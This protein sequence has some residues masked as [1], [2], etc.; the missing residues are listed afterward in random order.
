[1][2]PIFIIL[3][4]LTILL[5]SAPAVYADI[6]GS[7]LLDTILNRY[8]SSAKT[9]ASTILNAAEWLFWVLV[10]ISLVWTGINLAFKQGS[11]AEFFGEFIRFI[12]VVGL[13]YWLLSNSEA[14]AGAILASL[15]QLG[16]TAGNV[17]GT[18]RRRTAGL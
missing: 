5:A 10:V 13:F 9:W 7:G 1:M 14:I 17:A 15:K 2:K 6:N 4:S 3:A 11:I 12:I 18:N 8:E 16:S